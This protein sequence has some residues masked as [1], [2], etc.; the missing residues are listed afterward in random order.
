MDLREFKNIYSESLP[1]VVWDWC[2]KPTAEEI[3]KRLYEFSCMGI[4]C[5]FVRPAKGLV[6]G[7]LSPDYFELIR[8]AARRSEKYSVKLW[9]FDEN[10]PSSGHGGGEITSVSD[11]R[12]RDVLKLSDNDTIKSDI[13]LGDGIYLRDMASARNSGR[14][15]LSDITDSFVTECFLD[16]TYN[17]YLRECKRFIGHEIHGFITQINMPSCAPLFSSS[18]LKKLNLQVNEGTKKL[19]SDDKEFKKQYNNAFSESVA[20]NFTLPVKEKCRT[21]NLSLC[22]NVSG[23]DFLNRQL[24]YIKA[25]IISLDVDVNNPS[26]VDFKIA[27]SICAQFNKPFL[28]RL[29][30]DSYASC[31]ERYN[32]SF[33]FSALGASRIAYDSV[34]FSLSDRRKYEKHTVVLSEYKEKDILERVSRFSYLIA[35]THSCADALIVCSPENKKKLSPLCEKFLCA[36]ISFHIAE[37]EFFKKEAH[38]DEDSVIIGK[39]SYKSIISMPEINIPDAFSG[40]KFV[41]DERN[42]MD[43]SLLEKDCPIML[44]SE[45]AIYINRRYDDSSYYTFVT[46]QNSDCR[47]TVKK[48][49]KTIFIADT[50]NGEIYSLP[51]CEEEASFTLPQGST[52]ILIATDD[53]FADILP[54]GAAGIEIMPREKECEL[55]FVLSSADE[56]ILPL[57]RVNACFGKKAYRESNT[58]DLHKEFYS[59]SDNETVKAKYPFTVDLK[60]IGNVKAYIENADNFDRIELNGKNLSGFTPSN[61]DPRFMGVDITPY[62]SDGKNTFALEYKK[63]SNYMPDFSSIAPPHFYSFNPTTFEPIYLIGDFDCAGDTLSHIEEYS[64]DVSLSG[65]PYYYGAL[66]YNVQL[67][68]SDLSNAMISLS[69]DFDIC[70]IKIGKREKLFFTKTP[71]MEV[72][73]LDGGEIVEVTIFNTPYNLLRPSKSSPQPFGLKSVELSKFLQ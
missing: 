31:C 35:N 38:F 51:F 70:R 22:L 33:F 5:V 16:H 54:P 64:S 45:E 25:D 40:E 69:G 17:A 66:T 34:A 4:S 41:L 23:T 37:E 52:A 8:T 36:G 30:L 43:I 73:N 3:D 9:L 42:D 65:M 12:M 21:N 39:C 68:E 60:N 71:F 72:F 24:Q 63:F 29:L 47:I 61:K 67:P 13:P 55:N 1:S 19:L 56:N 62:L 28:L 11:Y 58:D 57:K 32:A 48:G 44:S 46:A 7:Y 10:S 27:E 15:P 18:A 2:A 14:A 49:E 26:I 59:L 20:E 50:S 6:S 53:I